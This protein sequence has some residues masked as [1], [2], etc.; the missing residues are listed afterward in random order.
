MLNKETTFKKETVLN[1][2]EGVRKDPDMI[3][4]FWPSQINSKI[5]LTQWVKSY[6]PGARRVIIFGCWYG[7][8]AD[9]LKEK[10]PELEIIC[11][12]KDP[13]PIQWTKTKYESHQ[14]KMEDYTYYYPVSIVINTSTEHMTQE[15]YDKWYE[16]IPSQTYFVIQGNNDFA[17]PDHRRAC[18]TLENFN[19]INHVTNCLHSDE[20]SYE[21]PW[22]KVDNK[23][24]YF[25]RFMSIGFKD[26]R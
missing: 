19:E 2:M 4:A 6:L 21:G 9:I 17:E 15:D 20:I 3:N 25:K 1:W 12:D 7:V 22:D 16:N 11:V 18:E 14:V 24:T 5:W 13:V 23:P 26:G 8:L 10:L